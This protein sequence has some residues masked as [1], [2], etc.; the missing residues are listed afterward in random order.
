MTSPTLL[1]LDSLKFDPQT[2]LI[3]VVT[4]DAR[5]GAVL[6]QAWA[7][8]AAVART[9]DTREATYWSRSRAQQWVKGATSGHTQ[10]VVDVQADC[11][12]DSLL[13]RVHQTG[14][15][16]HTGAYSCYHQPL[17]TTGA[18]PAGLDGTLDRVYATITERLATLPENSYVARLHAGGLDRVLKKISEESGEVLLAAKNANRAE[19]ATEVADLLFHTLFAMAEVGVS[20]ADVAAVLAEREGRTGL[21]GPKEVG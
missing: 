14:P 16:C 6:M 2:G 17:L 8:R 21:K 18:P 1:S 5:S 7:D 20:P 3:P 4:Q 10:Q 19:L 11:D 9:L 12:G 13:Y 15:A